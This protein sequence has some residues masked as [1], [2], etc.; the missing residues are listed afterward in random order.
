LSQQR[1]KSSYFK[2]R[3]MEKVNGMNEKEL[4]RLGS[5]FNVDDKREDDQASIIT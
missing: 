4:E 1:A 3:I 5:N 2:K